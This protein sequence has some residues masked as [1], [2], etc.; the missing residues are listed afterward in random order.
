MEIIS[1]IFDFILND[2][3]STIFLPALMFL[4]GICVGMKWLKSFSSAV[5]F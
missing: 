2:L 1:S 5:T 4:L 3:G